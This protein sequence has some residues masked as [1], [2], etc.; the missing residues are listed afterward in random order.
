M[1]S[2]VIAI[3]GPAY[4]GKSSISKCLAQ[5]MGYTYVNTGHMYRAVAK[6]ALE[7]D[8]NPESESSVAWLADKTDIRFQAGPRGFRTVVNGSDWSQELDAY[9]VVLAASKVAKLGRVR[10][11]LTEKQR[12]F[13]REEF[14]VMEGR[15]IGSVVFPDAA[16]KFYVTASVEVRAKRMYKMMDAVTRSRIADYRIL[17]P[18]VQA[19]DDADM[20]REVAPLRQ[21]DD[22]V[23]YDNSDSP[24]E[25]QDALILQYY[26][27]HG[28]EM[29]RNVNLLKGKCMEVA[30]GN[31]S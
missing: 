28:D 22:A 23:V 20:N 19:L 29:I 25:M 6:I 21:A 17:M 18:K 9:E 15:D 10:Q 14:I 27:R 31:H 4:V 5:L 24:S 12:A 26:I 2:S 16:W 7:Q 1:K 3:D 8:V 13:T 11:I 30:S